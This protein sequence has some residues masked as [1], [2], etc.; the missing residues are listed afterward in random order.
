MFD[1]IIYLTAGALVTK[2]VVDAIR[3]KLVTDKN[4][5]IGYLPIWPENKCNLMAGR[6]RRPIYSKNGTGI[7]YS[8]CR[9]SVLAASPDVLTW[10]C[11]HA[12][13]FNLQYTVPF[14]M[15]TDG[16]WYLTAYSPLKEIP[17]DDIIKEKFGVIG[18]YANPDL[19]FLSSKPQSGMILNELRKMTV[20]KY[21]HDRRF[22]F[23]DWL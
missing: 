18:T 22:K 20:D 4:S 15:K 13:R 9:Y 10:L 2:G 16:T 1:K 17:K 6:P 21:G 11:H 8:E 5:I 3:S 23:A 7:V 19:S 14:Y 12:S